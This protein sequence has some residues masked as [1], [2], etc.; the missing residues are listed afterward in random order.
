[1]FYEDT[2]TG[3]Q[4]VLGF[5]CSAE[6][7]S[8]G[9]FLGLIG[10]DMVRFKALEPCVFQEHTTRRKGIALLITNAFVVHPSS[11][12]LTEIARTNRSSI[13]IMRLFFTVWAFFC[14]YP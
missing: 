7:V 8:T 6:F 2:K 13:S 11:K 5:V 12:G 4:R 3:N 10:R 1:M 9:F 14:H